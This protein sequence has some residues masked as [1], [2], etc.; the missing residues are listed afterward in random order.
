[1]GEGNCL[2]GKISFFQFYKWQLGVVTLIHWSLGPKFSCGGERKIQTTV[3]NQM[4]QSLG[5]HGEE[6]NTCLKKENPFLGGMETEQSQSWDFKTGML[7][8]KTLY[9]MSPDTQLIFIGPC[10]IYPRDIN[11][12]NAGIFV[13]S[14][15]ILVRCL[16]HSRHSMFTELKADQQREN[17][18]C[19]IAERHEELYFR[20]PKTDLEN[21]PDW[22]L[23]GKFKEKKVT[24]CHFLSP[25]R[26]RAL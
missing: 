25:G 17:Q 24:G 8:L 3:W 4:Y 6:T 18:E 22:M 15:Q 13:F 16:V 2:Y 26:Q 11:S 20:F 5:T 14:F 1:M 9:C 19:G 12:S 21:A 23:M 7:D 10:F